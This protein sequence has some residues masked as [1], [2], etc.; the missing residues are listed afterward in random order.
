MWSSRKDFRDARGL[1]FFFP[2]PSVYY[3]QILATSKGGK[4]RRDTL[5]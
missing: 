3:M 4:M 5:N 1:K 2:N